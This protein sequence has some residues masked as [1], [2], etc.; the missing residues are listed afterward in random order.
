MNIKLSKKFADKHLDEIINNIY[1]NF[2]KNKGDKY[3]FDLTEVEYIAN[4]ELL[5]LSSL[6]SLFI[7]NNIDFEVLLFKKGVSTIDIPNRV[8][9][10]IIELWTVWGIWRIIPNKEYLKYFDLDG[11][12]IEILQKEDN[13]YPSKAELYG[14]YGVTP[15]IPLDFI[16]NYDAI[17]IQQRINGVFK[18]SVAIEEILEDNKCFHPFTS[19]SLSTI[20]AEELYLNFLDH[21]LQSAFKNFTPFAS[22]SISFKK[23]YKDEIKYQN[24]NNFE[25]E[26]IPETKSFFYNS[27]TKEFYN[28]GYIEFS[29]L[30]FGSGI[31][32]TLR[33]KSPKSNDND[34][35]K[36]A[37]QHNSSRHPITIVDNKPEN[38]IPRGLF[39]ALTIVRR[40]SGLLIARS[41]FGKILYD[42]SKTGDIEKAYNTFGDSKLFFPGTLI[43]LY[44]PSIEN[45]TLINESSIKP[46]TSFKYIKPEH[47]IYVNLNEVLKGLETGKENLYSNAL[48]AL[49][50]VILL[51]NEEPKIVYLSFLGCKIEDRIARK[52]LIYLMT[53]YEINIKTNIVIIHG[54]NDEVVNSVSDI[55]N[56]L[57]SVYKKYKIHPLPIINYQRPNDEIS[58][59]WLGVYNENDKSKLNELLLTEYSIA[60]SDFNDPSIIEGH[61]LSFDTHGNLQSN[62]P[63][64]GE[65]IKIFKEE[66]DK[67][68]SANFLKLLI[69][70]EGIVKDNGADLYLCN[71]NYYQKEYIEINNIINSKEELENLTNIFFKKL[72]TKI[73]NIDNIHFIGIT[74]TSNKLLQSLIDL[75]LISKDQHWSFDNFEAFDIMADSLSAHSE[76]DFILICDVIST[77]FLTKKIKN[78]LNEFGAKLNYVGVLVSVVDVSFRNTDNNLDDIFKSTI[79]LL[80]YKIDKYEAEDIKEEIINKNIIRINPYTN[81]PIRLSYKETNYRDSIIFHSNINYN[82]DSNEIVFEN[83]FLD[84]VAEENLKVGYYK[85][86][87][88]I[89]PYF[90]DTTPILENLNIDLL[91][92]T[93]DKINRSNL[94]SEKVQVFYPRE[95]G[96]KSDIFF[97]NLK[98]GLGN[99]KIE[100][101][102]I[103]RIN[104]IEGW[105]FPHNSKHLSS[106]VDNNLCLIIDDGSSTGDS[107][108]QMIDEISFYNAKEI[109]L[110]CFIGRINDHKREFFSRLSSINVRKNTSVDLSIYFATHWHIPTYYLDSNPITNETNWLK[111]L[112]NISNTPN[113]IKRIAKRVL[114]EIEPKDKNFKDYKYLP[115]RKG[116][117]LIPKKE[118]IKRREEIGKVIGYRLYQES[119]E[120]FNAFIKKYS[121]KLQD[122]EVNRYEEIELICACFVYE[123]YLYDKL[124]KILPDVVTLVEQFVKALIYSFKTYEKH[125]AYDWDKRDIIHLF[126]IVF[127]DDKLITELTKDNFIRLIEFTEPKES[128]LDYILYKLTKYFPTNKTD[129][130]IT[131]F[132]LKLKILVNDLIESK[133]AHFD[134]LKQYFIFI[135]TL[136]SRGTFNSQIFNLQVHYKQQQLGDLHLNKKQ[137][138]HYVSAYIAII[139]KLIAT[140]NQNEKLDLEDVKKVKEIW[141]SITKFT[142]PV[143]NFTSSFP[144]FL[145]PWHSFD[146]Y[147]KIE[148]GDF[149]V[150]SKIG[151][152]DNAVFSLNTDFNDIEVLNKMDGNIKIIQEQINE[153]SLFYRLIS[154]NTTNLKEIVE[155]LFQGLKNK[156]LD[157]KSNQLKYLDKNSVCSIPKEYSKELI[158]EEIINNI[159]SH[160]VL[161]KEIE[162]E[163]KDENT[164][165]SIKLKNEIKKKD[166]SN[167]TR[168]GLRC[169]S[170]LSDCNIYGFSYLK[171][172]SKNQFIQILK[173]KIDEH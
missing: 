138:G 99:D 132:D 65:L 100:V 18:L 37:F 80:D 135:S 11:S 57:S 152:N 40:Y 139:G 163:L 172:E 8:R 148:D 63:N 7:E 28:R 6:F 90:F 129:L 61:I 19:N 85:F 149:S 42:F 121:Q 47:K 24:K 88:V 169:L 159:I 62:F 154:N 162:I 68:I 23:K 155:G 120:Y 96:I 78:K 94:K 87:N 93:F 67:I 131:K 119:F 141:M 14:R 109:I 104:T 145:T 44:I 56:S 32:E 134:V 54:P 108:I 125:K 133:T 126:F 107:L 46:E 83:E 166:Y 74:S 157:V 117:N 97:R 81:I 58:I 30:D 66:E 3:I 53:D 35:L 71:G 5:V 64:E 41:N 114:E 170:N 128:S 111:E 113:N 52:I 167:S 20:I 22:L 50:K 151:Y 55:I 25:T 103:D 168:E 171:Y 77:G 115:K 16:N 1:D 164:S 112:I 76:K 69:N 118:L 72:Q 34:I 146:L 79:S 127:K 84:T 124:A 158:V 95:S 89:H 122:E 17:E 82:K 91:K 150:R 147:K 137:F 48:Q 33:S 51:N 101:I 102:E 26:Q 31:P 75:N 165:I 110:L 29:F 45:A 70:N 173:F 13:Y 39:D 73:D 143:L 123:P 49:R 36:F 21:S 60:K 92:K 15:F 144:E 59:K 105:R 12:S 142:T 116:T 153:D 27:K 9:K 160:G 38:H 86:N 10:Q 140:L 156:K 136:P 2:K 43:S 98:T 106:K 161:E 130:N 4:Q